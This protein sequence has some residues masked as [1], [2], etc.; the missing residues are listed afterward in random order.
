MRL[1]TFSMLL[2]ILLVTGFAAASEVPRTSS[3]EGASVYIISPSNGDTVPTTFTVI[4]GLK[5]MGVAPA[6]TEKMNTG[7]HHLLIDGKM[8]P[9]MDKP[10]G[11]EVQHFG[12][13]QTQAEL[14]LSPGKHTLQLIFGDKAHIPHD[15]PVTSE[16]IMINVK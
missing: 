1:L 4:F 5:G 12:G 16:V 11:K 6:G 7:H 8:M 3:P 10:L 14:M 2:S 15:P 9:E 13:G